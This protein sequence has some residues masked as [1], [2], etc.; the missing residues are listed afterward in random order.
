MEGVSALE[1]WA[2]TAS[3]MEMRPN[4]LFNC[5]VIGIFESESD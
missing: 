2:A 1:T 5:I 3:A 4:V